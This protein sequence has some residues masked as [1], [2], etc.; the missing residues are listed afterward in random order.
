[1][2]LPEKA[3]IEERKK[4]FLE[5]YGVLREQHQIDIM[6]I[7]SYVPDGKGGF[8]TVIQQQ[9][10]GLEQIAIPSKAEDFL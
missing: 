5:G 4:A 7:P 3:D 1:M 2:T 9:L 6:S 8:T 10:V